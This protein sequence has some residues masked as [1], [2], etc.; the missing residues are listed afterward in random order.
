MKLKFLTDHTGRE[1]AMKEYKAGAVAEIPTAQ[2]LELIR[3]G[4]AAE[5][6]EQPEKPTKG[7]VKK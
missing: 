4:V 2:A 1:T 6:T 7:K 5:V 3:L